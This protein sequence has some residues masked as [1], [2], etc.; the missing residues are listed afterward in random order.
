MAHGPSTTSEIPT[1]IP[2]ASLSSQQPNA[3]VHYPD[4]MESRYY[5]WGIHSTP[6]LL[7]RSSI[8]ATWQQPYGY[9][10]NP[11]MKEIRPFES[12]AIQAVWEGNLALRIL[13]ILDSHH[14]QWTSID[15]FR[16]GWVNESPSFPTLWIGVKKP[17]GFDSMGDE[18]KERYLHQLGAVIP[19]CLKLLR[20]YDILDVEVEIRHSVVTRC[21][22]LKTPN[23]SDVC[24][25][26]RSPFTTAVGHPIGSDLHDHRGSGGFF[27]TA[28]GKDNRLL[29]VTCGHI[30]NDG[31]DNLLYDNRN[32]AQAPRNVVLIGGDAAFESYVK[33]HKQKVKHEADLFNALVGGIGPP[34]SD[35]A[36]Y[37]K[38]I[39]DSLERRMELSRI[40]WELQK[41]WDTIYKR[42]LGRVVLLPPN[43]TEPT[44][45]VSPKAQI[46]AVDAP[47]PDDWA[48]I[49]VDSSKVNGANFTSNIL[50]LGNK[51][52]FS[53]RIQMFGG[54]A[55]A[56]SPDRLLRLRGPISETKMNRP[57]K[58]LKRGL[59]TNVTVGQSNPT[60][61]CSYFRFLP[62]TDSGRIE[63]SVRLK[64]WAIV[65]IPDLIGRQGA[66]SG[67]GDSGSV[68]VDPKGRLGGIIFGGSS[69]EEGSPQYISYAIP[70]FHLHKRMEDFG[71]GDPDF[72][73]V[74][75]RRI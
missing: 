68:V 41:S 39:Q 9:H 72:E 3:S 50:D 34:G 10:A 59:G 25:D 65:P 75:S 7:V 69:T 14:I 44:T 53:D 11:K 6:P 63:Q 24:P 57:F 19:E 29:L 5:Y 43:N 20:Q 45:R 21:M 47:Y 37:R 35:S 56:S 17:E 30:F 15:V 42:T 8:N 40:S 27:F 62:N 28:E 36:E 61:L 38:R 13:D 60:G 55:P 66:F 31:H 26:A 54:E 58:V 23:Y 64:G 16:F 73:P 71:L 74:L 2:H 70:L 52:S 12:H 22:Q 67:G 48:V 4:L 46:P 1:N 49:E 51:F 32:H 33:D 18:E